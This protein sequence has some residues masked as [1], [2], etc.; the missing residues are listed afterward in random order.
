MPKKEL[1]NLLD[2]SRCDSKEKVLSHAEVIARELINNW[3]I[4]SP[5]G[6]RRFLGLEFY[7][8]IPDIFVD[9]ATH[10]RCEQQ[11]S[12][13][14]YFH[15]KSQKKWTPPIFNRHGVDITCGN[16]MH[17]IYGGILLRHLSGNGHKDGSGLALRSLVRGDKGFKTI[18]RGTPENKWS[19]DEISFFNTENESSI[20]EGEMYLQH[21]PLT[22]EAGIVSVKRVG[23][24][25][26]IFADERLG[27]R[28]KVS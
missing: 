26:T 19:E 13:T 3:E 15:T 1:E 21:A 12:G 27:F 28:R 22:E 7:L 20:F 2:F 4:V 25:K 23:I 10:E 17:R 6:K 16:E 24:D 8:I 14:F 11:K 9:D 5:G 18:A